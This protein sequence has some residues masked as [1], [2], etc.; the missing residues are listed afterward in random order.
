MEWKNSHFLK[1]ELARD[2][3]EE[4]N[5]RETGWNPKDLRG[6]KI[7]DFWRNGDTIWSVSLKKIGFVLWHG[8]NPDTYS[9]QNVRDVKEYLVLY[10]RTILPYF[11][12]M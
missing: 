5:L 11:L 9:W 6:R 3:A 10:R 2:L 12:L 4:K 7:S 1:K 8:M